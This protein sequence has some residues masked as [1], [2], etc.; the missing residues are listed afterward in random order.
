MSLY[1]TRPFSRLARKAGITDHALKGAVEEMRKG[2]VHADLGGNV[3]KQRVALPGRGKRG[4]RRVI[5][6]ADLLD[7]G[8]FVHCYLKGDKADISSDEEY[9]FREFARVYLHLSGETI[10]TA[11][12]R[13]VLEVIV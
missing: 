2:I 5:V 6:A 9:A 13:G 8:I 10:R 1:K 4:G 11:V 12:E 7:R 3:Y